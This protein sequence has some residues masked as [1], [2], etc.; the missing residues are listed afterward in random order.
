MGRNHHRHHVEALMNENPNISGLFTS[1]KNKETE[2][3]ASESRSLS[4][5]EKMFQ[6]YEYKG[7]TNH[8]HPWLSS[9][10]N[11]AEPVK[12]QGFDVAEGNQLKTKTK[13]NNEKMHNKKQPISMCIDVVL[14]AKYEPIY[15]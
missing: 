15:K 2:A 4:F 8:I 3:G 14:T 10:V 5:E 7:G 12:F 11:Y 13:K 1:N 6:V 9:M